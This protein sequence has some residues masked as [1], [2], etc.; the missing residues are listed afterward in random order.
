MGDFDQPGGDWNN[1]VTTLTIGLGGR[2][3]NGIAQTEPLQILRDDERLCK[4]LSRTHLYDGA[5]PLV[6]LNIILEFDRNSNHVALKMN[7]DLTMPPA[8][9]DGEVHIKL[10]RH[11]DFLFVRAPVFQSFGDFQGL[12]FG[13]RI[14]SHSVPNRRKILEHSKRICRSL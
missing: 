14:Q 11:G 7:V 6:D 12:D 8:L 4:V 10:G 13:S 3:T 1:G 5:D 2:Q 9:I